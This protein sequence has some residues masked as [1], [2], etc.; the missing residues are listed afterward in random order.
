MFRIQLP[1]ITHKSFPE[2]PFHFQSLPEFR[3]SS[4]KQSQ[5]QQELDKKRK[6]WLNAHIVLV[7]QYSNISQVLYASFKQRRNECPSFV[8]PFRPLRDFLELLDYYLFHTNEVNVPSTS[9]LDVFSLKEWMMACQQL[10]EWSEKLHWRLHGEAA[11]VDLS[12]RCVPIGS[13]LELGI[14]CFLDSFPHF[15]NEKLG[16]L[17]SLFLGIFG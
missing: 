3:A 10:V 6:C 9:N 2:S 5:K 13:P 17:M 8:A 16:V 15:Q 4:E 1:E 12:T 7:E 14:Q 11:K